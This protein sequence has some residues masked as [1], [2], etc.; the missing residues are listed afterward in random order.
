MTDA[1]TPTLDD[2]V[3]LHRS[4]RIA[5]AA[6]AY[7]RILARQP[8]D[9]NAL[10]LLGVTELQS[11]KFAAAEELIA[12]AIARQPNVGVYHL[13]HAAA[14]RA[15][16]RID[17]AIGAAEKAIALDA[18]IA[19]RGYLIAG[20][21]FNDDKQV[22]DAI[23][24]WR[25]AVE[26]DPALAEA[27]VLLGRALRERGDFAEAVRALTAAA[28]A[29]PQDALVRHE[30]GASLR[31]TGDLQAAVAALDDALRL[32]PALTHSLIEKGWTLGE[33]NELDKSLEAFHA[34]L[35]QRP[36]MSAHMGLGLV[37]SKLGE[38][39]RAKFHQLAAMELEPIDHVVRSATLHLLHYLDSTQSPELFEAHL[40]WNRRHAAPLAASIQPHRNDPDPARPLRVGYV[41]ADFCGHP[42][43]R[44]MKPVLANC[45]RRNFTFVCY[46]ATKKT[47]AATD[48][49]QER[50]GEWHDVV[51]LDDEQ[52]AQRIRDDRI[53]ILVDLAGHTARNRLLTFARKPAPIQ[54]T[55]FG[56]TDTTGMT[57]M[58]YRMTDAISDP[59]GM[60]ERFHTEQLARLPHLAYCYEAPPGIPAPDRRP[61][62][63]AAPVTFGCI[64][65]NGKV[66]PA[67]IRLWQ[68]ILDATPG[69]RLL[70]LAVPSPQLTAQ[71]LAR[72][73]MDVSRV[74]IVQNVQVAEYFALFHRIDIAFDPFPYNGGI[75]TCDTLWMGVPLVTL[76][77]DRYVSRQGLALLSQVGLADLAANS[78]QEYFQI[79]V[80]LANDPA[81]R[82]ALRTT[83]PLTTARS[84]ICDGRLFTSGLMAFYRDAWRKWCASR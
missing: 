14:L 9:A 61:R 82:A 58:D 5:D 84:P 64:N 26:I 40:E 69:S 55:Q 27:Q 44:F 33:L 56:Y 10:H 51:K 77:G 80:A 31:K 25:K 39:K 48:Q 34:A 28:Q 15:L 8:D 42:V 11:E 1:D 38:L 47:D 57:A 24:C 7:R 79:A 20:L 17:D 45:D 74:A 16:R 13:N 73:G 53:D 59:P 67:M 81:R 54:C 70:F 50:A 2:A 49:L 43:A 35:D 72:H 76:T 22:D 78:E 12:K 65:N 19:A 6:A 23:F 68:R 3:Q 83:L 63:A 36:D 30:L 29:L 46:S 18:G 62:D 60:N 52:L 32:D 75:T 71:H 37:Y 21:A 41:S 4:G 66:T